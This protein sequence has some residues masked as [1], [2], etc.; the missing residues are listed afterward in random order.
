MVDVVVARRLAG[1]LLATLL[2]GGAVAVAQTRIK[3]GFNLFS[4]EQDVEIGRQSADEAERTL[5]ILNS[6]AAQDY[7]TAVGKRLAAVAPGAKYPYQFKIVNTSDINAFAL[8]G[9]FMYVNRGLIEAAKSEGQLA[10]VMA[11][12]MGHVALRHGTNQA[13]KAYLGQM[14]L[15]VMSG[16]LGR[17]SDTTAKAIG[18]VGGFGLNALF[19]K[20]SRTDESQ[21]DVVGAQMMARAGYDPQDMV[22]FF[23][24]LNAQQKREPGKVARFFASHPP[25]A[26]RAARIRDE[27]QDLQIRPMA[28]VGGF[29]QARAELQGLP[30]AKSMQEIAQAGTPP[31]TSGSGLA[32]TTGRQGG[33]AEVRVER[34][35]STYRA[36]EQRTGFFRIDVPDNWV[37]HE[38]ANGYG[39]T[40][41]PEGGLV[42]AGRQEQSLV[43]GVIVNHYD[44]IERD[45]DRFGTRGST[46]LGP[47]FI[48]RDGRLVSSTHL[49][50]A[51]SDLVGQILKSN[52]NLKV[53]PGSQRTDSISGSAALSVV[54]SGRSPITGDEERV[55]L[56]TRELTDDDVIYALVIAPGRDYYQL[57][58]TFNHMLNSL[59]VN[60]R[61]VHP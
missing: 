50:E 44:P 31:S 41:A 12:E 8:P 39:V 16:L 47:A 20:F 2:L 17:N 23:E 40:L 30:A 51:T 38:P 3:P 35:S 27:M 5:P 59:E 24:M 48:E 37:V 21:A 1:C 28:P 29:R 56:F 49:A 55:T 26:D 45:D 36:F 52:T 11:H 9:G 7:L 58:G 60:D 43:Y 18:A 57:S 53:V 22:S 61:A 10:G 25:P 13:S 15:G 32:S 14:G 6:P 4:V 34:P 42:D 46:G 33:V 19:L 54:L